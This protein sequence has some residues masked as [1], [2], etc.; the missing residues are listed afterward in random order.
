MKPLTKLGYL[1]A[2]CALLVTTFAMI[3]P[4][5]VR[6][7]VATL[8][9]VSNTTA[10]PIPNKNV[11][12]PARHAWSAQCE[13]SSSTSAFGSCVI[14]TPFN[15]EVVVQQESYRAQS[16]PANTY[17]LLTS[18]GFT[19][20]VD[21]IVYAQAGDNGL[22]QPAGSQYRNTVSA[23]MYLDPNTLLLCEA[24]TK[25]PNPKGNFTSTCYYS[26]YYVT[27]P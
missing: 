15:E 21:F 2:A 27:L 26:G 12:E 4:R 13:I 18:S 9:E 23:T 17:M 7:A 5:A 11:D 6:A 16:D 14:A 24:Q 8:V 25:A 22:S 19:A 10:N 1:A 20:G 3:G